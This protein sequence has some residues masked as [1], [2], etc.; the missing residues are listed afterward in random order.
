MSRHHGQDGPSGPEIFKY[1]GA[2]SASRTAA[3]E[4]EEQNMGAQHGFD[5]IPVAQLGNKLHQIAHSAALGLLHSLPEEIAVKLYP[6][7][8][9]QNTFASEGT[10]CGV[11]LAEAAPRVDIAKVSQIKALTG[12]VGIQ[13]L[14]ILFIPAVIDSQTLALQPSAKGL[15]DILSNALGGCNYQTGMTI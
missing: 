12:M 7:I 1:L 3:V 15:A 9:W 13:A 2:Q 14:E 8:G 6:G 10:Y 11:K 4:R 5:C